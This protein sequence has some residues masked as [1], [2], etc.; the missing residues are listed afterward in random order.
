M[1]P[2]TRVLLE[3]AA[4]VRQEAER[5]CEQLADSLAQLD[6]AMPWRESASGIVAV[7]SAAG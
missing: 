2:E 3:R 1:T 4:R 6:K 5:I 7:R